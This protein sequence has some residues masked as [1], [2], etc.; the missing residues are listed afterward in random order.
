[1]DGGSPEET[2]RYERVDRSEGSTYVVNRPPLSP[3]AP[4]ELLSAM[5]IGIGKA[6]HKPRPARCIHPDLLDRSKE[7][8]SCEGIA[9]IDMAAVDQKFETRGSGLLF[10]KDRKLG[11]VEADPRVS[12]SSLSRE[13][14]FKY[15]R[16]DMGQGRDAV[17]INV[18]T[19]IQV[20]RPP[21]H[22][23]RVI[24]QKNTYGMNT[25][26]LS[27]VNKTKFSGLEHSDSNS[28]MNSLLQMLYFIPAMHFSLKTHLS[29]IDVSLSDELGFLY[30]VVDQARSL[31]AKDKSVEPLNFL[32]YFR[33]VPEAAALG[34]LDENKLNTSIRVGA[35]TRFM[36]EHINKELKG[37]DMRAGPQAVAA[38]AVDSAGGSGRSSSG[39]RGGGGRKGGRSSR[40]EQKTGQHSG[41]PSSGAPLTG[42]LS[43]LCHPSSLGGSVVEDWFGCTFNNMDQFKS[44]ARKERETRSF[45]IDFKYAEDLD[46]KMDEREAAAVAAIAAA[47]AAAVPEA[48]EGEERKEGISSEQRSL[49]TGVG[50]PSFLDIVRESMTRKVRVLRAWCE[51]T[52]EY[53]A[54]VKTRTPKRMPP[55]LCFNVVGEG[56]SWKKLWGTKK[57]P[58]AAAAVA[59]VAAAA[60]AEGKS[61]EDEERREFHKPIP[62]SLDDQGMERF[63]SPSFTVR[64]ASIF[65]VS[66]EPTEPNQEE[67]TRAKSLAMEAERKA[68]ELEMEA[69]KAQA[70]A[71]Q[72]KT[73]AE[74]KSKGGKKNGGSGGGGRNN[75]SG[76][77]TAHL[78]KKAEAA[79]RIASEKRSAHS[80]QVAVATTLK[81]ASNAL[82]GWSG[83][84]TYDLVGVIS[85]VT[86]PIRPTK[87][88]HVILHAN[89]YDAETETK[90][91]HAC[92]DVAVKEVTMDEV[93]NFDRKW[94]SPCV[95]FYEMRGAMTDEE[96][97]VWSEP[98]S[99]QI[100][101]SVFAVPSLSTLRLRRE[102]PTFT[103]MTS[104]TMLRANDVVAIDCEFVSTSS[105]ISHISTEG[106]RV[107]TKDPTLALARV[108]CLRS[109]GEPFIDDYIQKSEHVMDYLTRFSG[110]IHGDLDPATS[111][112]HLVSLKSAYLKLR[113]LV[114]TGVVF[115]GH[116]LSKDFRM[117]NMHVPENQIVDTVHL[118]YLPGQRYVGLRFLIR[119]FFGADEGIQD[120][121]RGHD[122]IEDAW[123]A[124]RLYNKY[125]ELVQE[126]ELELTLNKLYED[127]H[128]CGWKN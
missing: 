29:G 127:G 52:K 73:F 1:M 11:Y 114:D 16:M 87:H 115:V 108:S 109:T 58:A 61:P 14:S 55:V 103:P 17:Y 42:V 30:H 111:S 43:D 27:N 117:I 8:E 128:K 78:H 123:G 93:L 124:L 120:A 107:V 89:V 74:V 125:R 41:S 84:V 10:G 83:L 106:R 46:A 85:H 79:R 23:R 88:G 45:V 71:A 116:G 40:P 80:A 48:V 66:R 76:G 64:P 119:Y 20:D 38:V 18:E 47:E 126:K 33:N 44:G 102:Q 62:S 68:S 56:E 26:D 22:L 99:V 113:W 4:A 104:H 39:G 34:L 37:T 92:N 25:Y 12:S 121:S 70:H 82:E 98:P 31:H 90:T 97:K 19:G 67:A 36:L 53:E 15:Q 57:Y 94:R 5:P 72:C 9:Y 35:C 91:W 6:T 2:M 50:L 49:E 122:S 24:M 110:L 13:I 59:A 77:G 51:E 65:H 118:F 75:N 63:L 69:N 21:R 7:D 81:S 28:F 60:A 54:L 86:D 105:E 3:Y 112:H 100:H 32:R 95:L 101:P 96:R